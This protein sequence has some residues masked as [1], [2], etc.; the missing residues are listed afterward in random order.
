MAEGID[1]SYGSGLG[2]AAMKA[3]GKHFVCRYLATLPNSKCITKA[4]ASNLLGAGLRI[5]LVWELSADRI[6]SGHNA[7]VADAREADRQASALGMKGIPLYFACDIDSSPGQQ[8]AI[9]AYLDGVASVIGR[10]RTG[11]YGG[12]WPVSRAF[13]AAKIRYGW[14][15]YAWSGGNW[16]RRA[17][18]QQYHN[19]VKLGPADVD[20]DR[21]MA[22]DY[23]QWPRPAA[24]KPASAKALPAGVHSFDGKTSLG[25]MARSRHYPTTAAWIAHQTGLS[26]ADAEYMLN[27]AVP[28]KG[29]HW[30]SQK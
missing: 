29:T 18:I 27:H 19:G 11:L 14:Q 30:R 6:L 10:N 13:S 26:A 7:G 15:S 4:E 22:T 20:L 3:A 21:S 9:N 16:D 25:T 5:V 1:Y 2:A 12:Y 24:P 28:P 8:A 23:G 17:Q